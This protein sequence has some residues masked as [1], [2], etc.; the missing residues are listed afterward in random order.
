[1]NLTQ[2]WQKSS[3]SF[4]NGNCL[5]ARWDKST[6]S[7]S[8]GC[9]ETRQGIM[10]QIRDSK[11]PDGPMLSFAPVVFTSFLEGLKG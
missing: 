1:M 10:V 7:N 3:L 2:Y 8:G 5:E 9:L 6:H 4:S 11:N